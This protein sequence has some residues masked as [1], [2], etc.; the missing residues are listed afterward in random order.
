MHKFILPEIWCVRATTQEE[1]KVLTDYIK[2]EFSTDCEYDLDVRGNCWFSNVEIKKEHYEFM[3]NAP[4]G[5]TEITYQEFEKYV[6]NKEP[7]FQQ[8]ENTTELNQIL[9][10]LLTE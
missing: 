6:L 4:Q 5:F 10:K 9:I 8:S 7:V 2:D 1:D 3:D